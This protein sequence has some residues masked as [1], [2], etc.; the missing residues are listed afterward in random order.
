MSHEEQFIINVLNDGRS[1]SDAIFDKAVKIISN[2]A[3]GVAVDQIILDKFSSLV[4]K[5]KTQKLENNQ[6]E[7]QYIPL[8]IIRNYFKMLQRNLLILSSKL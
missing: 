4:I 3:K 7:V 5:L 8:T 2:P 6:I 1:Y